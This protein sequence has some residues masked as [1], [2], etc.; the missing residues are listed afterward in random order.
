TSDL[1]RAQNPAT[2]GYMQHHSTFPPLNQR[3]SFQGQGQSR[4]NVQNL[5]TPNTASPRSGYPDHTPISGL[6]SLT[7]QRSATPGGLVASSLISASPSTMSP[8]LP[9]P[10]P[11][12]TT[13]TSKPHLPPP[14]NPVS[15]RTQGGQ[16]QEDLVKTVDVLNSRIKSLEEKVA[17]LEA[18]LERERGKSRALEHLEEVLVQE[19]ARDGTA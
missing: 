2:P 7:A 6:P 11:G 14:P 15:A 19:R 16:K 17:F 18:E 12:S 1:T 8:S 9:P 10:T 13:N 4:R 5:M 3:Q